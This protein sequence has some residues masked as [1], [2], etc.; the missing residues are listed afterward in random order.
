MLIKDLDDNTHNWQLIGN[1]AHSKLTNKSNLHMQARSLIK[2]IF[3]TLVVLE[4]VPIILRKSETLFLDFYLPLIKFCIEVHGEQHYK[5]VAHYHSNQLGFMKHK[6]R[7]REKVEWCYKN[8]I[9]YIELPFNE[10]VDQWEQRITDEY[11]RTG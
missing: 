1:M 7:D 6:K 9:K 10:T 3:P 5:F 4:E 11:K 2:N 8:D